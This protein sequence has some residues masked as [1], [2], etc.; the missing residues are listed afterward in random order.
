[1][2]NY[3]IDTLKAICAIFVVFLHI[4]TPIQNIYLPIVRCAVPCFFMISGYFL[5]NDS[6]Q[7]RIIKAIRKILKTIIWSS[8]LF[9]LVKLMLNKGDFSS[10]IPTSR[11]VV[12]FILLNENPLGFHLWYLNAYL[13]TLIF[14]Y[15]ISKYNYWRYAYLAVPIL[16]VG[17]LMLGKY[18]LLLFG[19]EFDYLY[20]RNFLFVG[21]PNFLIG[22][23]IRQKSICLQTKS[24]KLF[25]CIFIFVIT[26][27]IEKGILDYW[28]LGATR[29]QYISTALLSI[30]FFLYFVNRKQYN[31]NWI[32]VIGQRDSLYIYIFHP[33]WMALISILLYHIELGELQIIYD[34]AAPIIVLLMTYIAIVIIRRLNI[35]R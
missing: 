24:C 12:D 27:L 4:S 15:L 35:I 16:L 11:Q 7:T 33:F 3:S 31:S 8:L 13:Y 32:S 28:H 20:V 34:Y 19:R 26:S 25:A 10:I 1:M 18:S 17:D 9:A 6:I 23:Y 30:S 5:M 29:E 21:I 2:R 14:V 22:C